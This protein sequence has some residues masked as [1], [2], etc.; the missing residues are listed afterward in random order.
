[1]IESGGMF[2]LIQQFI[3]NNVYLVVF[4]GLLLGGETI[5]LPAIYFGITGEISL[6]LVV[7]IS[8]LATAISDSF[9]YYFGRTTP[10]EKISSVKFLAKY[11]QKI[12]KFSEMFREHSL[13][14]L[15]LS[16]F[17]YGTRTVM[18][19]LC[20]MHTIKFVKYFFVNTLGILSLN[21]FFIILG[22]TIS[23]SFVRFVESPNSMWLAL[24]AFAVCSILIHVILNKFIFKKWF[25]P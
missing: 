6:P 1:M 16:K 21:A 20:G 4:I 7:L 12:I 5:L 17:V 2:E 11:S 9:W 25:Q 18:Q 22:L 14:M 13:W 24:G 3:G 19:I 15:Y 10:A 8:V 23:E